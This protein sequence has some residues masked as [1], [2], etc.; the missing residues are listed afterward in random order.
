MFGPVGEVAK[1]AQSEKRHFVREYKYYKILGVTRTSTQAEIKRA[2]RK[3]AFKY[4]PDRNDELGAEEKFKEINEAY[5]ILSD[6]ECR[7]AYDNSPAECPNC[8]T[9]KVVETL[10]DHWRCTR[11]FY[12]FNNSAKVTKT[13]TLRE[14]AKIHVRWSPKIEVFKKTQCS[15]CT[16]FFTQPFLC[17]ER[18]LH[19]SCPFFDR[20]RESYR[21]EV[22]NDDKWWG[23][24]IDLIYW[25][26]TKG[27]I[28]WCGVCESANP[29]PLKTTCW[30]CPAS[31]YPRCPKDSWLLDYD[32]VSKLWKCTN[33]VH[34]A[35]LT[36]VPKKKV[37]KEEETSSEKCLQCNQQLYFDR[38]LKLY[39]CHRCNR[40]Y[41]YQD[42]HESYEETTKGAVNKEPVDLKPHKPATGKTLDRK[43]KQQQE[44]ARLQKVF[45]R[46]KER[47][48]K[49]RNGL[50]TFVTIIFITGF[51]SLFIPIITVPVK[52]T[53][54]YC[55]TEIRYEPYTTIE[56]QILNPH[57]TTVYSNGW[58]S[59]SE[60]CLFIIPDKSDNSIQ[61]VIGDS[62]FLAGLRDWQRLLTGIQKME[63]GE[64]TQN[65]RISVDINSG[66]LLAAIKAI[67]L[68]SNIRAEISSADVSERIGGEALEYYLNDMPHDCN[69]IMVYLNR[70]PAGDSVSMSVSYKWDTIQTGN[71]EV[72]KYRSIPYVVKKERT[73]TEDT[74]ISL[75]DWLFK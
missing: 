64:N 17:P 43:S 21:D 35:K 39:R 36:Y 59:P 75:W 50:F 16:R 1:M 26:E 30:N 42:L 18:K 10:A 31:I 57:Q 74:K 13:V 62:A 55:E 14:K 46:S 22:L 41:T 53:E 2:F 44:K 34:K 8:W 73:V 29:N 4:H 63:S 33:P 61:F 19:S 40:V 67:Q 32:P 11:C 5:E 6:P 56:S 47:S 54:T 51:I 52:I 23:R 71:R 45:S 68:Y 48:K 58:S 7:T 20:L 3:L 27:V 60:M 69:T 24:I 72:T 65:N 49:V 37:G 70:T 25:T 28:R 15:W 9:Y 38:L 66:K 12:Q